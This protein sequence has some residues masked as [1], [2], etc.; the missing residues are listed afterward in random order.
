MRNPVLFKLTG[1]DSDTIK[2]LFDVANGTVV[3]ADTSRIKIG[4]KTYQLSPD[5]QII[6]I[7]NLSDF[8]TVG[9]DELVSG[10]VGK[11]VTLYSD[12]SSS[13]ACVIRVITIQ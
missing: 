1:S 2:K 7:S 10:N 11:R 4:N 6:D 5:V 9:I 3:A 8:T 12:T 13:S